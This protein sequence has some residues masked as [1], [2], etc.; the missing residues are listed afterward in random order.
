L[1]DPI[2][3]N[4]GSCL[5]DFPGFLSLDICPPADIVCDLRERWPAEDS[6]VSEIKAYDL[7]E[8]LPDKI[9]TMN[10][11]Y[12]CLIPGGI[13]DIEVPTTDGPGAW[14]DPTHVSYWNRNSFLY[15]THGDPHRERFDKYY[16]VTA[17]FKVR[18]AQHTKHPD[19][20]GK[21]TV[22]KLKIVLEAVKP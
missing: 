11:A 10:E 8:H 1:P 15:Y 6:T 12:R 20:D 5:R 2:R 7:I 19:A 17:R 13:F 3:W 14:Q 4:I 21:L 9:H 18:S 16:G 22:V